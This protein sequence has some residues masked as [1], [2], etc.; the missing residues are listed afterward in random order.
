MNYTSAQAAKLLS[1]LQQ[2]YDG[3]VA[4]EENAKTFLASLGEDVESVRPSY[5]Y[6]EIHAQ[7][8]DLETKIRR[9]KHAINLFNTTAVIPEFDMTVDEMLVYIPQLSQ[10]KAKLK[11]M[12]NTMPKSRCK[13]LDRS[14]I[15]DYQYIN[16][17]LEQVKADL[18]RVTET[19]SNA[20]LALDQIN[21]T[22]TF[23]VDL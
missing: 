16:Y 4:W 10:K 22:K 12:A 7:L 3:L 20:Q 21:H 15:I 18:D 19:L 5:N 9:V 2:D 13:K 23:A 1:K 8:T 6:E 17:D 14:N 11:E